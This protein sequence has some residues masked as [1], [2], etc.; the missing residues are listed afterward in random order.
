MSTKLWREWLESL[1]S[2]DRA[3]LVDAVTELA[4]DQVHA[5]VVEGT[6]YVVVTFADDPEVAFAPSPRLWVRRA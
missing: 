1:G 2:G 6:N 4:F 5:S 3:E